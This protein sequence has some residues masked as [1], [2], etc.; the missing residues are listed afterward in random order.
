MTFLYT[1][2]DDALRT[3]APPRPL[4]IESPGNAAPRTGMRTAAAAA[5]APASERDRGPLGADGDRGDRDAGERGEAVEER[6]R[7]RRQ[8]G[9]A[10]DA[11][12]LFAPAGVLFDL[13]LQVGLADRGDSCRSAVGVPVP[14]D[15]PDPLEPREHV[16]LRDRERVEPVQR[17]RVAR[18]DRVVPA[19]AA[20][21]SGGDADLAPL[22]AQPLAALVEKLRGERPAADAGAVGLRDADHA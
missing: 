8:I 14:R 7:R 20:R 6:A 15:D 3:G 9:D 1:K 4:F 13:D 19:A 11:A 5:R 2:D 18:G 16:E 21:P 10:P 22:H 12:D 17:G